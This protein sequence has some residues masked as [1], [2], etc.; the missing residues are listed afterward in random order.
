MRLDE[1]RLARQL[2][3]VRHRQGLLQGR[4]GAL[5]F[6]LRQ[7]AVLRTLT[8]DIVK[9]SEVEGELLDTEQVRSSLARRLGLDAGAVPATDR[10]VEGI[11]EVMVD[12]TGG[13]DRPLTRERLWAWHGALFP[14]GR[15]GLRRVRVGA[16]RDD[17][18]G[19]MQ[20]VSGP[21][22]RQ[23]VHFEAPPAARLDAE[24]D[25]F[26]AWFEGEPAEDPVLKAALAHLWFVTVHPF[27][28]GNGRIARAIADMALAR[29]EGSGQRFYSMSS[30]IQQV[31]RAYYRELERAQSGGI[32]V[33]A[34]GEWFLACLGEAVDGARLTLDSVL[35]KARFWERHRGVSMNDRQARVLNR[36]LDGF[37]GRLTTSKWAAV[38]GCS[39]DTAWRDILA[40]VERG[41]LRRGA[42][43][44]RSTA[45]EVQIPGG[46]DDAG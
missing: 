34:W 26:L 35:A 27:E 25:A 20:V 11:V 14:A 44:G 4:M 16:W 29:S 42:G 46:P 41:V 6:P 5:G 43:G 33:S 13:F 31:R 40:L 24:M 7:E 9:S 8:L 37:E 12:A 39:Q 30:R 15:S 19:P 3:D 32:D 38:A 21:V 36:V 2:A 23:R 18:Q 45:Y 1:A 17:E 22:G 28:D 10:N